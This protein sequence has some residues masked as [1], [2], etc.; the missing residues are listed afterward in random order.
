MGNLEGIGGFAD[1]V[2]KFLLIAGVQSAY[3]PGE[4]N[5]FAV[6]AAMFAGY[7]SLA[8][9][10]YG[11]G[12]CA[13]QRSLFPDKKYDELRLRYNIGKD[14]QIVIM[15]GIGNMKDKVKVPV[16]Y[17]WSLDK[18]YCNLDKK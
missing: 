2:D 9:H 17:R 6:S 8:L 1:S 13:V 11:I 7:L 5:Q 12:A 10:A 4:K 15:L 18:I 16:S 3:R 14:E